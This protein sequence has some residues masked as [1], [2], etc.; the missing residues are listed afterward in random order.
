[1]TTNREIHL[2]GSL[3]PDITTAGAES[4]MF[5][6][7]DQVGD[8]ALTSIPCDQDARWIIQYLDDLAGRMTFAS[9]RQGASEGYDDMPIYRPLAEVTPDDVSM[10]RMPYLMTL[11]KTHQKLGLHEKGLPLQISMPNPLDLSL[12]TFCGR[13][14]L[15]HPLRTLSGAYLALRHLRTFEE[16]LAAEVTELEKWRKEY[17]FEGD[18]HFELESPAVIFALTLVPPF[19]R[20][21]AATWLSRQVARVIGLLP[22]GQII[23][24]LC[25]GGLRKKAITKPKNLRSVVSFL[26][27][28]APRVKVLPPVHIPVSFGDEPPT[29]DPSFFEPLERLNKDYRLIAGVVAEHD[30]MAS[31]RALELFEAHSGRT[32]WAIGAPCGLGRHT[33]EDAATS[34]EVTKTLT[35]E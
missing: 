16:A 22:Q 10:R 35:S 13:P 32:A 19:L 17:S 31:Q 23:L 1:M 20:P 33:A 18:I 21:V 11:L 29:T 3:P 24:H 28:L 34:I 14:T 27:K 30:P 15:R 8:S 4:A 26:N 25:V 9:I 7:L 6:V 5:W 12:F 2:V